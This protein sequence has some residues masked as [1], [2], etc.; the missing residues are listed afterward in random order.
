MDKPNFGFEEVSLEAHKVLLVTHGGF[1]M[2]FTNFIEKQID[3]SFSE[4]VYG[5]PNT[6]VS[7]IEITKNENEKINYKVLMK[8]DSSHLE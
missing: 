4:K 6:C 3:P 8:C 1:I 2:E 5:M 7:I